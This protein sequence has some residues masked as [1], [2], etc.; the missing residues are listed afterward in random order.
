MA[1]P[2]WH[3]RGVDDYDGSSLGQLVGA[4]V[5][6]VIFVRDYL[7]ITLYLTNCSPRLTFNVWPA[8]RSADGEWRG[9][10]DAGYRDELCRLIDGYVADAEERPEAGLVLN[11]A[12]GQS[13]VVRPAWSDLDGPEIAELNMNDAKRTWMVWRPGE[14]PFETDRWV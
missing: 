7:Q 3:D 14:F 9:F 13:L 2:N 12:S 8:M 4:E 1:H 5:E 10:G 6:S 11:F